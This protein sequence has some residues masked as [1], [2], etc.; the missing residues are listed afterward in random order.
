M[1]SEVRPLNWP[2]M[3]VLNMD[4]IML[5]SGGPENSIENMVQEVDSGLKRGNFEVKEWVKTGDEKQVK[6]LS[7]LYH[8]KTDTFSVRPKVNWSP[9]K[10]G[11]RKSQDVTSMEEL[12]DH[13]Y[14]KLWTHKTECCQYPDGNPV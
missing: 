10:R 2:S 6:F 1:F 3:I 13:T 9:K 7:Y 5:G 8:A 14:N 4:D 11:V 12:R